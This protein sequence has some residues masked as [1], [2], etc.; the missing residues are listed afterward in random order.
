MMTLYSTA[1]CPFSHRCRIVLHEKDMDFQVIDVDPNNIPED[2]AVISSY[3]KVPILVER[4]LVLYEANIINEYIDD[5]F[6]HPQ[7]MPAEPVMRARA[8]LLLH[9]FEKEL[10]CHIESLEQGDH[11]TADKAR[12]EIADGLTMIAPIFEKQKYML[13]DEYTMLDVAIAPLLWRLDH[14][15]VKLPKQAAPL[16]KYAERLFSRPLFIDALTPSEKLMRK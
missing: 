9:R 6:P 1:T 11:K 2:I 7:L 15:G 12:A 13:G 4:D 14:Y 10:F 5:R 3:S 16:L 8:R